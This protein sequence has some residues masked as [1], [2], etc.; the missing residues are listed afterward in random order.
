MD[1]IPRVA[2]SVPLEGESERELL[3]RAQRDRSAFGEI[4]ARN[5]DRVLQYAY[6]RTGHATTAED[7]VAEVF[8]TALS[9]LSRFVWREIPIHHWLFR[10]ANHAILRAEKRKRRHRSASIELAQGIAHPSCDDSAESAR[11]AL[12]KVAPR[13]QEVLSLHYLAGL[14]VEEIAPLLGIAK[15]T[16]KSRLFRGREAM[17]L[18][19]GEDH[20]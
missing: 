10:I 12:R 20:P 11:E 7:V 18:L 2:P 3:A 4:Y 16:V 17:R 5:Y 15:G 9:E 19:L 8:E 14:S 6:R 1:A 13:F